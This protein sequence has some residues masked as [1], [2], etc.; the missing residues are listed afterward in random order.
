MKQTVCFFSIYLPRFSDGDDDTMA[1]VV[2]V[3]EVV[4]AIIMDIEMNS[5][6]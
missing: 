3:A 1:V 6:V 4:N 5:S 2:V